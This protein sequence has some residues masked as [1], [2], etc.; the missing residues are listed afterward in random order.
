M[1]ARAWLEGSGAPRW[2]TTGHSA[3]TM[4]TCGI[5]VL[6]AKE[7]QDT[8]R[9]VRTIA[10]LAFTECLAVGH[11][12]AGADQELIFRSSLCRGPPQRLGAL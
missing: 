8:T 4:S 1:D 5:A 2:L 12:F 6:T 9:Y 11:V 10:G 3:P 7:H